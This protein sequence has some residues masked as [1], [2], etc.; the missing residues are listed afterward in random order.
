MNNI[1]TP[2]IFLKQSK[3][4]LISYYENLK[5]KENKKVTIGEVFELIKSNEFIKEKILVLR[6]EPN[7]EARDILKKSLPAVT[8][9]GLFGNAR[10][11]ENLLEHSGF[12]QLD[13]D[14]VED[15]ETKLQ[16]LKSDVYSYAVFISPSGTGIKLIVKISPKKETHY[17]SFIQLE[18]YY[19]ETYNL[20]V[21]RQCK[22]VTRLLF[23]SWDENIFV[24]ENSSEW[25]IKKTE[26]EILFETIL[27]DFEAKEKFEDGNRN[28]FIFK[29]A[30]CCNENSIAKN[31]TLSQISNRFQGFN[32]PFFEIEKTVN[33]AYKKQNQYEQSS[34][35]T[36]QNFS[37]L[38]RA[39][40]YLENKYD[41]RL[42]EVSGKIEAKIKSENNGYRELNENNIYREL[43]H[44]NIPLA[45]QKISILLQSD[46][47]KKYDPFKNYFE[48]LGFWNENEEPKY[49]ENLCGYIPVKEVKR[50]KIQFKKML[51]RCI[52]C[53]L[54]NDVFN[55]Q[56]FV[57][58]GE[59]QN[60]GKSTFCRWLCP[61]KLSDYITEAVNT[62]K[63]GLIVLATNFFINMDELATLSKA[64]INTLKSF[65]SKD[66][67]NIRL[68]FAK[69]SSVHPRRANF[70]GSTNN[71]EF[72][73]DETGSVRW[74]CFDI[75]GLINFDY[76]K[77]IEIDNLWKQA[78][79]LYKIGFDYQLSLDEVKE[80]EIANSKFLIDTLE[81]QF[82]KKYY[83]P[84][85]KMNGVFVDATDIMNYI[86]QRNINIKLNIRSI[87]K[88]MKVLGFV[89]SSKYIAENSYSVKGYFVEEIL[90]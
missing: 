64:E 81:A 39:E 58:V 31:Y 73:T 53:A 34:I 75:D 84:A 11:K 59:G 90:K 9:S 26:Q 13:F 78:Y 49:I 71:D 80:N 79:T 37:L 60:T 10:T 57:L 66:K 8:I 17:K 65:I 33:S 19:K 70:I 15:L 74:L 28:N 52:A 47:V 36:N 50:F 12:L 24:N 3:N 85:D 32:F 16:N 76:K 51:V 5:D 14:K 56:V 27:R 22:D 88:A 1:F 63:D 20:I 72:L 46:F 55:K 42:N 45:M 62:D 69:R 30:C 83:R 86:N 40:N 68:P 6:A 41:I 18:K 25:Q 38:Q 29:L 67:I 4:S 89:K 61:P 48:S 82:I 2:P 43:Q 21:D 77:D 54:E 87:G 44:S 35:K 23:L 7:K